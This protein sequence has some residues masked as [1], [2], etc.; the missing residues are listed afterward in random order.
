MR[1]SLAWRDGVGAGTPSVLTSGGRAVS[2]AGLMSAEHFVNALCPA[3]EGLR[4]F[5]S[6]EGVIRKRVG[7]CQVLSRVYGENHAVFLFACACGKVRCLPP[8]PQSL[9]LYIIE[10]ASVN[11]LRNGRLC[12]EGSFCFCVRCDFLPDL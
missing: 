9:G 1:A 12:S 7:L 3:Q 10:F 4:C 5:E 2:P 6:A 8:K 11:L